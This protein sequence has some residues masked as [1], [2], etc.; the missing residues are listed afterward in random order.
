MMPFS[1]QSFAEVMWSGIPPT[2]D[3][4]GTGWLS[5]YVERR[6]GGTSEA[7]TAAWAGIYAT[8]YKGTGEW[9]T[10]CGQPNA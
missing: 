6:Y 1:A 8:F 9:G 2:A 3:E 5:R 7:A 10:V 4:M